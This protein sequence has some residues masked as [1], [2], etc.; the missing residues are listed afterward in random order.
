M[1]NSMDSELF[2]IPTVRNSLDVQA[3]E[4]LKDMVVSTTSKGKW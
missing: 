2:I 4:S 1:E 3:M